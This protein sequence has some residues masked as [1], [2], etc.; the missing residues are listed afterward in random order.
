MKI[1]AHDHPDSLQI[2]FHSQSSMS[3]YLGKRTEKTS[4]VHLKQQANSI[5]A[6]VY[7][8]LTLRL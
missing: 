1:Y 7:A 8:A 5:F 3:A 4:T 6:F 2:T